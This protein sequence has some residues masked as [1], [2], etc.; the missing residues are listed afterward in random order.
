M[1]CPDD[2]A[3]AESLAARLPGPGETVDG[4]YQVLERIADGG[5]GVVF[6]AV[7]IRARRD[8]ALKVLRPELSRRDGGVQRFLSEARAAWKLDDPRVARVLE[9]RISSEGHPYQAME[10]LSGCTLADRLGRRGRLEVIE[11]LVLARDLAAALDHAHRAGVVHGDLKPENVFLV[12]GVSGGTEVKVIDFGGAAAATES[13]LANKDRMPAAEV[14]GTPAYMS[15]EQVRGAAV[16]AWTDLYALGVVLHE[17]LAGALPFSGEGHAELMQGHVSGTLPELPALDVPPDARRGILALRDRLM[18]KDP[19]QRPHNAYEV[20]SALDGLVRLAGARIEA[21]TQE[22]LAA[23]GAMD[24]Q[25]ALQEARS[26]AQEADVPRDE[27]RRPA[28]PAP[29]EAVDPVTVSLVH[30]L[31]DSLGADGGPMSARRL[32]AP[33][34]AAFVA[35]VSAQGGWA[36]VDAPDCLRVAF[37]WEV[38]EDEPWTPAVRA[39]LDL[40]RRVASF[41]RGTGMP[42]SVRI[43]VC[44]GYVPVTPGML[45]SRGAAIEGPLAAASER[46]ARG[47][48][49]G[50]ILL[51]DRT[52][53]RLGNA[54]MFEPVG[55][56]RL[57]GSCE[58]APIFHVVVQECAG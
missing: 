38:R 20:R 27:D 52:R 57:H 58:L 30:V 10:L 24:Y 51:D 4:R 33:E 1:H 18:A 39:A 16:D 53:R 5:T 25:R 50:R 32:F 7:D 47:A 43:G 35:A 31:F 3:A 42:V 41:G 14:L 40:S 22:S 17:M 49:P 13:F 34:R 2:G 6:R 19:S 15:P 8:V 54:F 55:T 44:T 36:S 9:A 48:D 45:P 37:G 23:M 28:P 12:D 26:P 29:G 46:L 21:T 11:A 56:I